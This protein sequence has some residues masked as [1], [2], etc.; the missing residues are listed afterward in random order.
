MVVNFLGFTLVELLVVIAIIGVLIALLLPAVQAAREASRRMACSNNLKQ[1]AL[2]A[3][4]HHDTFD[5]LPPQ[6][7]ETAGCRISG[8]GSS[9]SRGISWVVWLLPFAEQQGLK[10][11]IDSGGTAASVNGTYNFPAGPAAPWDTNYLPWTTNFPILSCPSDGNRNE[12]PETDFPSVSSYRACNGDSPMDWNRSIPSDLGSW[13]RGAFIRG[14]NGCGRNLSAITD[15]T[16]NTLALSEGCIGEANEDRHVRSAIAR[17]TSSGSG[18]PD[19]CMSAIDTSDRRLI[20]NTGGWTSRGYNGRRWAD[21]QE[22]IYV[23]FHTMMAPNTVSCLMW[24]TDQKNQSMITASSYHPGGVNAVCVDGSVHFISDTI[25]VGN[26]TSS[27]AW[28]HTH[29]GKSRFGIW[30]ALGSINGGETQTPW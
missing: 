24:G 3:L 18:S 8:N 4:N 26:D 22:W 20:K 10:A 19:W 15:G 7:K 29:S 16:S 2:A 25:D 5:F 11:M 17:N 23:S 27:P 12:Q 28:T 14:V 21:A 9:C 6:G 13:A 1:W 30:G